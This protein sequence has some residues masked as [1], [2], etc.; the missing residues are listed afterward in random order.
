MGLF[1]ESISF[2]FPCN[3]FF[4]WGMNLLFQKSKTIL[5]QL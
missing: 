1:G 5:A 3:D 2:L 4:L